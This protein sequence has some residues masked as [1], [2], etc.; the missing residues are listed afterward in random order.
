MRRTVTEISKEFR[1]GPLTPLAVNP[2]F[3]RWLEDPSSLAGRLALALDPD[4]PVLAEAAGTVQR[5]FPGDRRLLAESL[6]ATGRALGAPEASL[7]NAGRLADPR[8]LALVT[9]QQPALATGPAYTVYKALQA[10]R[11]ARELEERWHRP[12]VPVFWLAGDDH[13]YGEASGT[14]VWTADRR[15]MR[16]R[17]APRRGWRSPVAWLPL[18]A[19]AA[20]AARTLAEALA[21]LEH[22]H[23]VRAIL[24]GTLRASRRMGDWFARQL[25]ALLGPRGLVLCDP[26]R[27][28]LRRLAAPAVEAA[29]RRPA[30]LLDACRQGEEA[31]RALGFEP[32]LRSRPGQLPLFHLDAAGA[33]RALRFEGGRFHEWGGGWSGDAGAL[34]AELEAEPE[35]FSPSAALRPVVQDRLLPTVAYVA[36][37]GEIAYLSQL[38]ELY[39][40]Y[41]Q[42]PPV[43]LP[44]RHV[45]VVER[46]E[47]AWLERAGIDLEA[48]WRARDGLDELVAEAV[49]AIRQ[50]ATEW[51]RRRA[52]VER[53]LEASRRFLETLGAPEATVA[54]TADGGPAWVEGWL[55]RLERRFRSRLRQRFRADF[56]EARRVAAAL[57]PLGLPQDRVFTLWSWLARQGPDWLEEVARAPL[58]PL[59]LVALDPRPEAAGCAGERGAGPEEGRR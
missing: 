22:G 1:A 8:S 5:L 45:T 57:F 21:P 25:L 24:E 35:R 41:G 6:L 40:F 4:D 12:V 39:A 29:L 51:R 49:P 26:M 47:A 17:L 31:V 44:R 38:A 20:L 13:D 43:L 52:A 59:H 23:E 14:Y 32:P 37:P 42:R 48:L 10:V 58:E 36:G 54:A 9:G 11:W 34:L 19:D 28:E 3:A 18:G 2:L 53:E 56:A 55:E 50:A 7:A 16:V 27:P 30:E 15:V 46:E 33:R